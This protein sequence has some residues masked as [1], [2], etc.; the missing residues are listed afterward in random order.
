VYTQGLGEFFYKND[1]D[2]RGLINFPAQAVSSELSA[3]SPK[4]KAQ[5]PKLLIPIGGGKDS[6]VTIELLKKSKVPMTLLRVGNHPLIDDVV[7][8]AGVP[9]LSVDRRLDPQLFKLNAD[10]ALNGHVPITAYLSVLS[11]VLGELYGFTDIAFSDERSADEGN[12]EMHGMTINHQ[13][14]KSIEFE[15]A[16]RAYVQNE[17]IDINYF[18]FLRPL[19]ELHIVQQFA[20]YPQYFAHFTSCNANWRILGK[21]ELRGQ[22]ATSSSEPTAHS[23]KPAGRWCGHCP[24]CAFA[25]ALCAAFLPKQTVI[26]IFETNLF[27]DASLLPLYR[28]LLGIEGIKPFECVGTPEETYAALSLADVSGDWDG[29]PIMEMFHEQEMDLPYEPEAIINNLLQPSSEH[30][31]PEQFKPLLPK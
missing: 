6:I 28:E 22:K 25:F 27:E 1:V 31:I 8:I 14:S 16:L 15:K 26:D 9:L 17:A 4:P 30:C 5:S 10:G 12:T 20:Q 29:T 21:S 19:S 2:F 18:S 13:W 3:M 11:I 7:K 23:S 24:K